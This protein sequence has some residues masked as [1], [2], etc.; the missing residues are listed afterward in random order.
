VLFIA[1]WQRSGSTILANLLGQLDGFF[2][3][4]ELYYLWDY[5]WFDRNACGCGKSVLDCPVW[6]RVIQH[7]FGGEEGVDARKMLDLGRVGAKTSHMP[8]LI[9]PPTRR[10]LAA[11]VRDYVETLDRLYR[12]IAATC[13]ARV[14]VDS[15][16]WPSYG[17][18]VSLSPA[19]DLYVLH[20]IRDSRAVAF[21]WLRRT[22][23]R[24]RRRPAEMYRRPMNGSLRWN[25][26][27]ITAER[28]WRRRPERYLWMR[29]EDFVADP[30][31]SVQ[32]ILRFIH[33]D[34]GPLPFVADRTVNLG[35]THTISGNPNRFQTGLVQLRPDEE[36]RE[37]MRLGDRLTVTA[38][39]FPLLRRY[40]YRLMPG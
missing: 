23:L 9:F 11:R 13:N 6:R 34:P 33:E 3:T 14:I 18:L 19:V 36:W 17:W 8:W 35:V 28:L 27:N 37:A 26:W 2:S 25:V 16:K 1:G 21:S 32:T 29:Y 5:V 10:L 22:A 20:L 30:Q 24:D 38:L 7:G 31:G 15:S 12:G 4:G 40:G 39:T